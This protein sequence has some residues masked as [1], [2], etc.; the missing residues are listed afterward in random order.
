MS[1]CLYVII[2]DT[3]ERIKKDV[4]DIIQNSIHSLINP[5]Y[6]QKSFLE[7]IRA[8]TGNRVEAET[9]SVKGI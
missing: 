4:P 6:T 1:R 7:R 8:L 3:Y 2:I 5:G 9:K